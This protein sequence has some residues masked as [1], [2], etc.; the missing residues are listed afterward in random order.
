MEKEAFNYRRQRNK[1]KL[2][3][4]KGRGLDLNRV[5]NELKTPIG[6]LDSGEKSS[7]TDVNGVKVGHCTLIV[8]SGQLV[9]G[10]GPVRTGVTVILPG[11]EEPYTNSPA[12]GMFVANGYGKTTGLPQIEELGA[13]ETPIYL[14]NTLNIGKVYNA[15]VKHSLEKNPFIGIEGDTVNPLVGECNDSY[16]NDIQGRHVE[17][18]HVEEAIQNASDQENRGGNIGAGTGMVAYGFKGGIGYSSRIIEEDHYKF[19]LGALLLVNFGKRE[20]LMLKGI[21][22]GQHFSDTENKKEYEGSVIVVLA[23]DIPL[24]SRQLKRICRRAPLGLA[25]TGSIMGHGSGDFIIAFSTTN[26]KKRKGPLI[27]PKNCVREQG[28][29]MNKVFQAVVE[30]VEESVFDALIQAETMIGRDN[31][32]VKALPPEKLREIIEGKLQ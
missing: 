21:P 5:I 30:V 8:G 27:Y 2:F 17:A 9:P 20:H 4:T 14:T 3:I 23:T 15:A 6:S 19:T 13:L 26:R 31:R 11:E 1:W 32:Q 18:N 7:I 29:F 10:K 12:C 16:L 22:L 24:S 28:Q 25:R